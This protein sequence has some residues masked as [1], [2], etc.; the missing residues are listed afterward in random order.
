MS[1]EILDCSKRGRDICIKN[2]IPSQNM[3][4]MFTPTLRVVNST[5]VNFRGWYLGLK[6]NWSLNWILALTGVIFS[7]KHDHPRFF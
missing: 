7:D 5:S 3:A 1:I 2:M 4:F 6:T